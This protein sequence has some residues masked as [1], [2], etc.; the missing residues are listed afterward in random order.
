MSLSRR[1]IVAGLGAVAVSA[2]S[3]PVVPPSSAP[4][5][6]TAESLVVPAGRTPDQLAPDESFWSTVARKYRVSPDF[7]NLENGYYGIMPE[8]VRQAYHRNV[9][10][11][12]ELNSHLLRT[13]YTDQA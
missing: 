13:S 5:L 3:P 12:N 10:Q 1:E 7:I 9:D 11:L 8:P 2:V 4:R 6:P